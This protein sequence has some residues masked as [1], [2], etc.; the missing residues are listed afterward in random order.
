MQDDIAPELHAPV[1]DRNFAMDFFQ[2]VQIN[3][4]F[5]FSFA[6]GAALAAAEVPG[7][8]T[9][10]I[11]VGTAEV[12]EQFVVEFAQKWKRVRMIGRQSRRITQKGSICAFVRLADFSQ[13][14]EPWILQPITQ[15]AE[16]ILVWNEVN[17]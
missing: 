7:F 13:F 3:A 2:K 4:P 9:T 5:A 17:S 1:S 16:G 15:M 11:E 6:E 14:F 8:V 10:D 12:W